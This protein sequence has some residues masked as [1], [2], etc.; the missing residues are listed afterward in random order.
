MQKILV[1]E[2]GLDIRELLKNFLQE[3]DMGLA[4]DGVEALSAFLTFPEPEG[5]ASSKG[6]AAERPKSHKTQLLIWTNTICW[7]QTPCQSACFDV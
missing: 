6:H 2:D 7:Q 4:N 1:A 5:H 3:A